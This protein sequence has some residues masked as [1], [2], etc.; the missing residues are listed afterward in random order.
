[1][2]F[3]E[4]IEKDIAD[5]KKLLSLMPL[6]NENRRDKY[7]AVLE[8]L[9]YSYTT[10]YDNVLKFVKYKYES[11]YP[12][13]ID[14]S[15]KIKSINENLDLIKNIIIL[16]NPG[17]SYFESLGFDLLFLELKHYYNNTIEQ[18]NEIII[19]II[20]IF[21]DA[22]VLIRY[23]DFN[24]N[25]FSHNYMYNIFKLIY[26]E[27][28]SLDVF[29]NIFWKCPKVYENIFL[30]FVYLIE[31]NKFK[32]KLYAKEH[33]K[34]VLK[35]N[36]LVDYDS[37]LEKYYENINFKENVLDKDEE[38]IVLDFINGDL[39]FGMYSSLIDNKYSEFQFFLIEDINYDDIDL[40]NK[41]LN[42]ISEFI[43][44]YD[45]Y[46]K[47]IENA[48]IFDEFKKIYMKSIANIDL[49]T[50]AKELKNKKKSFLKEYKKIR[51][52]FINRKL[53]IPIDEFSE[54][55]LSKI[56]NQQSLLDELFIK[57]SDYET[58][59]FYFN[60]RGK[61]NSSSNIA[62]VLKIILFYPYFTKSYI[63]KAFE[64]ETKSEVDEKYNELFDMYFNKYKRVIE[65]K[66]AFEKDNIEVRLMD[67]FRFDNFNVNE[68]TFEEENFNLILTNYEKLTNKLK[69]LK[70]KRS[71]DEIQFLIKTS[72][73]L[74]KNNREDK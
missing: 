37:I 72:K 67:S 35:A 70:F 36:N 69:M 29:K 46:K 61:I 32:L 41:T 56:S 13:P 58:N 12:H 23:N 42:S 15:E 43:K 65:I 45:E 8:E 33:I 47:Y 26:K 9:K 6:N 21:F 3:N 22:D 20:K 25:V 57:Y 74:E 51:K 16:S 44:V 53:N 28:V 24:L 38:E 31:I 62:S 40:F 30:N 10:T 17:S 66:K 73:L 63:K 68:S 50:F 48:A 1:M 49:K 39:D 34:N 52:L 54:E 59:E 14:K 71:I 4:Y 7:L 60:V 19:K 5:K 2:N 18:N 27:E 55:M 11:L 64:F